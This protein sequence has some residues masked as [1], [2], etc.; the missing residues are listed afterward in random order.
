MVQWGLMDDPAAA[1]FPGP[2][3][4]KGSLLIVCELGGGAP[5]EVG[6]SGPFFDLLWGTPKQA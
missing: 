1:S 6:H 5:E 3:H 4:N 2:T